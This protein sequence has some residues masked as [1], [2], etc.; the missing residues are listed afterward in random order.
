MARPATPPTSYT[1]A[2]LESVE[3]TSELMEMSTALSQLT[4]SPAV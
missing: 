1:V 2:F 3:V 4:R